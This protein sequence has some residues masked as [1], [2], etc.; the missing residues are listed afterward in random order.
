MESSQNNMLE[1][2]M[3]LIPQVTGQI[4]TVLFSASDSFYKVL[5]LEISDK[6]FEYNDDEITITGS[7]G[8]IQIGSSYE[9]TGQLKEHPRYGIQ[10]I[11]NN[12]HRQATS[13]TSGLVK[14]L[15][16]ENFPGVG[17]A[18][19]TK[20]VDELGVNAIELILDN[21]DVLN[22]LNIS[23]DLQQVITD[24]LTKA[25]GM[26]RAIIAL[27]DFGFGSTLSMAIYQKYQ[28][29]TLQILK[30]NPYQ[31][32]RDIDGVSFKRID[33]FA[34]QEG[35]DP[36]DER[37][38]KAGVIET[39]NNKTFNSGDTYMVLPEL[40][41][42]AKA[43][44]DKGQ[45]TI[46]TDELLKKALL[47]LTSEGIVVVDGSYFYIQ[48]IYEAENQIAERLVNLTQ[49]SK[50][51]YSRKQVVDVLSEVE[52]ANDFTY[53]ATQKEAIIAALTNQL[54]ILTGGPGTG[55]TTIIS[56]VVA[57][58]KKLL[59]ADGLKIDQID[60]SIHLAAPTGRAAKRLQEST[61]MAATTIHH[62]LGITGREANIND[63][64]IEE[65][66]GN[67][68][69]IDEMSMVDTQLFAILLS[70]VQA[71]MQ[72]ILV[73]DKDQ[74]PSVG[75]GRVFYDLLASGLLNYRELETIH[76]Q[77]KGSTIISL[78]NE[79][80]NGRLPADFTEQQIDRS[81][82][83]ANVNTVPKLVEKIAESWK[84]KGN[85]VADMQILAPM[86]R[87][88]AGVNHLNEIVQNIFNP[89]TSKKKSINIKKDKQSFNY[90]V[91]D[92]VMQTA[93]DPENNVFNGDIGYITS[94][95]LAKDKSNPDKK[96]KLVV[97]FDTGEVIY[98]RENWQ[99][100]TLAYATTIH[101]SQGTEYKLVIM[102]LVD[103]FFRMLQRNLLYTGLTRAS[104][105]LVLIGQLSAY[106]EAVVTLGVDR[107]TNLQARILQYATGKKD[108]TQPVK[109]SQ[110]DILEVNEPVGRQHDEINLR[111][112]DVTSNPVTT[113]TVLTVAIIEQNSIDPNIG[114]E[115][116][117]PYDFMPNNNEKLANT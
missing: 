102:P 33:Q 70:A 31:L 104:E 1:D 47:T 68:L 38:I 69:V 66:S 45:Q 56:G 59:R 26:E 13:T 28:K 9:F 74:L 22:E 96:D 29:S 88:Q 23:K 57:T 90:R 8:D 17:K 103:A 95:L 3:V 46:M 53:D 24:K 114:L 54:F 10:F 92:K 84:N 100:I 87:T 14:Y 112:K 63:I 41:R 82:F 97:D 81:F 89:A 85:S 36:L 72:I 61:G 40:L 80:K 49:Q 75:P 93:N 65:I 83:P 16:S 79:V 44:L 7:F 32:V 15:S 27:N 11:A 4:Q 58:L 52:A 115:G 73:G 64:D 101:K 43:L 62:L 34:L 77:G 94:V 25:D 19:A 71:D 117:T 6:N 86:Y 48:E 113:D 12:Y 42:S 60:D 37:R 107:H 91:G 2:E 20:I 18:T 55:K 50:S 106:Q 39:I 30:D 51:T 109:S 116:L 108:D 76:R 105:S 99:N 21:A 98:T 5:R 35:I 67:L 110:Q 78:A 111:D